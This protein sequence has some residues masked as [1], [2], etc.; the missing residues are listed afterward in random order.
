MTIV[1]Q[2]ANFAVRWSYEHLFEA[3][4]EKL[5]TRILDVLGCAIGALEGEPSRLVRRQ[6]AEFGGV[7]LCS[8]NGGG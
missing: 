4:R 7:P 2:F 8:L 6:V 3:A 5:K 1:E